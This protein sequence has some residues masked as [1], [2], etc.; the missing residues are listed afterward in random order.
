M[1]VDETL[2]D[3]VRTKIGSE[4]THS[5]GAVTALMIRRYARAI[6]ESNPLYH[7]TE[8]A[9]SRGHADIVAPPNLVTAITCWDEG[10]AAEDLRTDGTPKAL[11]LE[12]IPTS[13]VRVMGGGEDM[14]FHAP[15]TAG[16]TV[17]ERSTMIDAELLQGRKGPFIVVRYRHEFIGDDELPLVT[18]TRKVLLR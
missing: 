18:S 6:G 17:V 10:P 13:G 3:S 16:T 4:T 9:R 11:Q 1:P 15:I 2:L 7:D 12:G 8:F 5:L 14:E